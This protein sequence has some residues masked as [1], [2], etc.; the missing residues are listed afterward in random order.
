MDLLAARA[1]A[2][3]TND[4]ILRLMES[5]GWVRLSTSRKA[6]AGG[7]GFVEIHSYR[8][9]RDIWRKRF[10]TSDAESESS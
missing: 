8:L 4:P 1:S 9:P 10:S 3:S 2:V 5:R 7:A 6:A